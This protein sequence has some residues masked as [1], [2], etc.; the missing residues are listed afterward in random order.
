MHSDSSLIACSD[1]ILNDYED[2]SPTHSEPDRSTFD[3][4]LAGDERMDISHAGGEF[5]DVEQSVDVNAS[6]HSGIPQYV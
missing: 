4:V 3:G 1:T 6:T 2:I 5:H